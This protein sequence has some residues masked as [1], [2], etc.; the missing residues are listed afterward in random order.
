MAQLMQVF[1]A[2]NLT[3]NTDKCEFDKRQVIFLGHK[4]DG[5][6][7]HIDEV[8]VKLIREF[9][10]PGT[11]SELRSFLGLASFLSP[12]R[13]TIFIIRGSWGKL[14]IGGQIC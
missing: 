6:G 8:K 1:K 7:F 4:L 10:V 5:Q 3:L 14:P 11:V 13:I 2:N 12:H 9:R